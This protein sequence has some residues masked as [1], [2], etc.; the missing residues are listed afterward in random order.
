MLGAHCWR[1]HTRAMPTTNE[2]KKRHM[3]IV[4]RK[5]MWCVALCVDLSFKLIRTYNLHIIWKWR[6]TE[7]L[8][9]ASLFGK[10]RKNTT[11]RMLV[12]RYIRHCIRRV[13]AWMQF[14]QV[15]HSTKSY[16]ESL[17]IASRLP[18]AAHFASHVLALGI[19]WRDSCVQWYL[20]YWMRGF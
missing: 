12:L 2:Q 10:K 3:K 7:V 5:C 13:H 20:L 17:S 8:F 15:A 6:E 1:I 19:L 16:S 18:C 4:H 9:C 11:E 14:W